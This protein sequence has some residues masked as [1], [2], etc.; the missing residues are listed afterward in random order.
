MPNFNRDFF[1]KIDIANLPGYFGPP[2]QNINFITQFFLET[3]Q[4]TLSMSGVWPQPIKND[5]IIYR[6]LWCS[7]H[8]KSISSL[9][10]FMGYCRNFAILLFWVIWACL[11]T[12]SKRILSA[13]KKLWCLSSC[14]IY[15]SLHL[16]LKYYKNIAKLCFGHAWPHSPKTIVTTCR[17]LCCLSANSK[18]TWS[19]FFYLRYYALTLKNPAPWL[20]KNNLENNSRTRIPPEIEFATESQELKELSF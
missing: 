13:Y 5:S 2:W 11:V 6:K 16:F 1:L 20:V 7:L 14:K 17:K 10:S 8:K 12:T 4:S 3:L 19:M 15:V 18:S 9:T